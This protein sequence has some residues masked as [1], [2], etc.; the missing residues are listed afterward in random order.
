M[1]EKVHFIGYQFKPEDEHAF[2]N[3]KLKTKQLLKSDRDKKIKQC[4]ICKCYLIE[5][6][7][8]TEDLFL[9]DE[10]N[11]FFQITLFYILNRFRRLNPES[12]EALLLQIISIKQFEKQRYD[13]LFSNK[14]DLTAVLEV[15]YNKYL[16]GIFNQSKEFLNRFKNELKYEQ[17]LA[18]KTFMKQFQD[19]LTLK[20]V[21]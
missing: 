5:D 20:K 11:F 19:V 10:Y 17:T 7:L 18:V 4:K 9:V 2:F 16:N 6:F 13:L 15:I 8:R 12:L 14:S 1:E 21:F 3:L